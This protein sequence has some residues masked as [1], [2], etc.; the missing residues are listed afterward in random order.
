MC[1]YI[2]LYLVQKYCINRFSWVVIA[3]TVITLVAYWFFPYKYETS[4]K[5]IY[6]IS[7]LFRW[8]PYFGMML[9]GAWLGLKVR[10]DERA[11]N[12]CWR[13]GM[14][15][16]FCLIVFYG[17]QFAAKKISAVAPWQIITLPFLAAVVYYIWKC[18]NAEILRKVY[19]STWGNRV[20]MLVSGVC[21]ESY[22]FQHY[23][24]T[25]K[26]NW[27]F[28]LNI[29]IITVF[30][31]FMSYACRCLARIISQTFRTEDYEWRK[32]FSLR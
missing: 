5:G 3:V 12:V 16:L 8:I 13:D 11:I 29:P 22:L 4:S 7:T 14:C 15:L 17:V 19:M 20:I 27:L 31:L 10:A 23:L 18:C 6:G 9:M 26:L 21:L 32:V 2:L 24:F 30:I 25:D 28:P 1:Y